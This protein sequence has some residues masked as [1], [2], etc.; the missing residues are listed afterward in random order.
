MRFGDTGAFLAVACESK[1]MLRAGLAP[2]HGAEPFGGVGRGVPQ[3]TSLPGFATPSTQRKSIHSFD[4]V[5]AW[6]VYR[7][8]VDAAVKTHSPS[9]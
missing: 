5:I 7:K 4:R 9:A 6:H 3:A 2:L 8:K 1:A